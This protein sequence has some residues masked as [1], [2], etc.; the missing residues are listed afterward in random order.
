[1]E[2]ATG[3]RAVGV[4]SGL[5][6]SGPDLGSD[7]VRS[8]KQPRVALLSGDAVSPTSL[9]ACWYLLDHVYNVPH[10][11]VQIDDLSESVLNNYTVLVF[12]DDEAGGSGYSGLVDSTKVSVIKR[13]V[14]SGGVFVGLGG[15]AFFAAADKAGLSTVKSLPDSAGKTSVKGEDRKNLE[16]KRKLETEAE[17]EHRERIEEVPGTIF[18]IKM[19]PLH[20]L[21]FGYSGE[22]QVFKQSR[23]ALD[24]GPGGTNVAWFTA[25]ARVSGYASKEN[26]DRFKEK[27]FLIDEPRGR[28]HVVL[29][30]EDP[31]FRVFWYGL[32]RMFLN[33][34]YFLPSMVSR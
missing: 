16:L 20:P 7:H 25:S 1:V 34:I 30:V 5:T 22:A 9:G 10:S 27:P 15:G 4:S 29:Y 26:V 2:K 13:W 3:T 32:N 28:G 23:Q 18:R 14:E 6:D 11:L 24:L 8:L 17:R 33:S 21:S 12:P 31:N 19:D